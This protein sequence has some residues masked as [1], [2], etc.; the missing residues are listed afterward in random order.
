MQK[1]IQVAKSASPVRSQ[2]DTEFRS[3]PTL[4]ILNRSRGDGLPFYWTINPYRGCAFGCIYCYA[5]KTHEYLDHGCDEFE[6]R[7][8]VKQGVEDSLRRVLKPGMLRNR[9]VAIGTATDPYQGAEAH[10]RVTRRILEV[11]A[12][13][14]DL[15]LTITT[16]SPLVVRDVDLLGELAKRVPLRINVTITTLDRDLA[17]W[18]EPHAPTPDRRLD[19]LQQL[20]EEGIETALFCSPLVPGL[21]SSSEDLRSLLEAARERGAIH[22]TAGALF[23]SAGPKAF[24]LD[25]LRT[26]RPMVA[27]AIE[28]Q[29]EGR[30]YLPAEEQRK[31][32]RQFCE[33]ASVVGFPEYRELQPLSPT[34]ADAAPGKQ[35]SLG[36]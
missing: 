14:P 23:L 35:L 3:L 26:R 21:N 1:L 16:K 11:L 5:R 28:K 29:F 12:T 2:S 6:R 18:F 13:D 20:S 32:W 24:L 8:Y 15:V 4:Q 7:I 36:I 25:R 31:V 33:I 34:E 30:E 27:A 17:S 22:A 19:T 9:P 10:F